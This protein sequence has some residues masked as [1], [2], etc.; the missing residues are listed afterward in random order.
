MAEYKGQCRCA[1]IQVAL[2]SDMKPEEFQPRSDAQTCH[3]CEQHKGIWISDP[4]GSLIV[5]QYGATDVQQFASG[6]VNFHFCAKCCELTYAAYTD[7]Q[8]G[9]MVAVVRRDL[10]A[11]IAPVAKPVLSTN[12]EGESTTAGQARRLANWT[13]VKIIQKNI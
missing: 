7:A 13:P 2:I 9:K 3:F 1:A 5:R 4:K 8:S 10:F 11:Q 6:Q 12:F